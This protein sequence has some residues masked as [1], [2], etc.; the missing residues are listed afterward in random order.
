[1]VNTGRASRGCGTCRIRRIKCDE[2]DPVCSKCARSNRICLGYKTRKTVSQQGGVKLQRTPPQRSKPGPSLQCSWTD[3]SSR[4]QESSI[5]LP[6]RGALDGANDR[7]SRSAS[8]SYAPWF[9]VARRFPDQGSS[10]ILD[11]T[12]AGFQALWGP[13][14]SPEARRC[15][16]EKY[17]SAM[18]ELRSSLESPSISGSLLL[19]ICLFALYEVKELSR[20]THWKANGFT[21]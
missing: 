21:R 18:R 9:V 17:Q 2:I 4:T 6:N 11:A 3:D 15:L 5:H 12:D 20:L 19:P 14:Q 8:S 16:H 10:S 1:M 13:A 7:Q